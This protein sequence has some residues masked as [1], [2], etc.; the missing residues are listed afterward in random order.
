MNPSLLITFDYEVFLGS[1]SGTIQNCLID[2][3]NRVLTILAK[4]N[5]KSL[6][7]VDAL[8]LCRLQ[9]SSSPQNQADLKTIFLQLEDI[10]KQG[11]QIGVHIHPHWL[12]AE[13]QED[14]NNWNGTN[15]NH[16]A[17]S[18][19]DDSLRAE[20]IQKSVEI[21]SPYMDMT[22]PITYR[23]GGFYCQ[24]FSLLQDAFAQN[25]IWIDFSVMRDFT[26][27]GY[28]NLFAFDFTNPPQ[29]LIYRFDDNP[30]V[31]SKAGK[32]IEVSVNSFRLGGLSRIRNS[33]YFRLNRT[34][35]KMNRM[36]DGSGSGNFI[37]HQGD[38]DYSRYF[39]SH[40]N[41]A[42]ELLNPVL[43]HSYN[44][45]LKEQKLIHLVSHP[46][47]FTPIGLEGFDLFCQLAAKQKPETDYRTIIRNYL[48]EPQLNL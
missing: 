15:K 1:K 33:I 37:A 29:E 21:L 40:Q 13:Y 3:T 22:R 41:Y 31:P 23:A 32:F 48:N 14:S 28:K 7:F 25:N 20:T 4:H 18:C 8:Y 30:L 43:A 35:P 38:G 34:S 9:E 17:L 16:F 6:F 47:S 24:P 12:D 11:H 36:G 46:K 10:V 5:F 42:V 44:Q 45:Q 26:S 39:R 2:P 27:T 19:L